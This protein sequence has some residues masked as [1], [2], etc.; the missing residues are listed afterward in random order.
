MGVWVCGCMGLGVWTSPSIIDIAHVLRALAPEHEEDH[1]PQPVEFV[2]GSE[3]DCAV[4][5][6]LRV[7]GDRGGVRA[8]VRT[9]V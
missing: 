3:L 8:C 2:S 6:G 7:P 4:T 9:C 1:A 5:G